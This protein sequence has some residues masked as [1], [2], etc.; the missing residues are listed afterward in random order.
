[1]KEFLHQQ[2]V[3]FTERDVTKDDDALEEVMRLGFAATPV[4]VIDG[5]PVVG[6]NKAKLQELLGT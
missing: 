3:A 1:M 5:V 6:F 2:G 4:T